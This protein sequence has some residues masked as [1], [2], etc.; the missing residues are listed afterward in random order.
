MHPLPVELCLQAPPRCA[1]GHTQC[2]ACLAVGAVAD[3]V[4]RAMPATS[5][6]S[7]MPDRVC[8]LPRSWHW[9]GPV[10]AVMMAAA[11]P[12]TASA[13]TMWRAM[14][15]PTTPTPTPR[16]TV[17][18][19]PTPTPRLTP[20]ATT[21]EVRRESCHM[22]A[23]RQLPLSQCSSP[24]QCC[25]AWQASRRRADPVQRRPPSHHLPAIASFKQHARCGRAGTLRRPARL[26]PPRMHGSSRY[27]RTCP[28]PRS[29][30]CGPT[31]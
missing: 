24:H 30:L 25:A 17:T 31:R 1:C 9:Q 22:P 7:K 23:G 3:G 8:G 14:R 2:H 12:M 19:R 10:M 26:L 21:G 28:R 29:R 5:M 16:P 4:W 15:L 11:A 18:P 20:Q 27:G 13:W 6:P